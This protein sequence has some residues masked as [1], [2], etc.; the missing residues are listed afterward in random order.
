MGYVANPRPGSGFPPERTLTSLGMLREAGTV[1]IDRG[2]MP[3]SGGLNGEDETLGIFGRAGRQRRRRAAQAA[4]ADPRRSLALMRRDPQGRFIRPTVSRRGGAAA[5]RARQMAQTRAARTSARRSRTDV[6]RRRR[7]IGGIFGR[8]RGRARQRAERARAQQAE[9]RA[10]EAAQIAE[11]ERLARETVTGPTIPRPEGYRP[12]TGTARSYRCDPRTRPPARPGGV[13]QC[14]RGNW[15]FQGIATTMPVRP[16]NG[17]PWPVLKVAPPE[18]TPTPPIPTAR[19]WWLSQPTDGDIPRRDTSGI[20]PP[21]GLPG[22][23]SMRPPPSGRDTATEIVAPE[24][25]PAAGMDMAKILPL[26]A[27]AALLMLNK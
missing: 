1:D 8:M 22:G 20:P 21:P 16:Q 11:A 2:V 12:P 3:A 26:V 24:A 17:A 10:R 23:P 15:S 19:P 27:G 5:A 9:Q 14:V 4:R 6:S 7:G 25:P 13:W 18:G